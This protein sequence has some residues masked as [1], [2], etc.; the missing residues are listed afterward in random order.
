MARVTTVHVCYGATRKPAGDYTSD[1]A[2]VSWQV[3]MDENDKAGEISEK[4]LEQIKKLVIEK[5][6]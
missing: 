3:V 2:E 1:H 4:A 6:K 5:L